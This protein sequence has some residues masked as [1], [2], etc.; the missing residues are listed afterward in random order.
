MEAIKIENLT[1][2][3]KDVTAVD[4]LSLNINEGELFSLLGV[5]G[6][7]KTTTIKMLSCLTKSTSGNAYLLGKS[8]TTEENEIKN[9]IGV[10]PQETAVA[11]G[12]TV[13]EN[14]DL[15]CGIYG[16]TKEQKEAKISELLTLL[17]LNSVKNKK[18]IKLSGGY[19][20]RL[21]IALAL[22]SEPK[23]L[24]LDE[25][26]LG[27]DVIARSELWDIIKSLKSKS[28]IILTTHYM[29][30]AEELSDRVAIMKDGKLLECDTVSA[31]KEKANAPTLE[32]AFI[33]IVKGEVK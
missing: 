15:L 22:V 20:R 18:A 5:N 1:K 6:A 33:K 23:I 13:Y 16:Y 7:G 17:S 29:E 4:N 24:F 26:T 30:E 14:L 31:I 3:Y 19:Q 12:L 21:S 28:T 8:I 25:P 32:G 9:I 2:K 11:L 27:L 10:S